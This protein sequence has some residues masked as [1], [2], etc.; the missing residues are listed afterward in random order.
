MNYCPEHDPILMASPIICGQCEAKSYPAEADWVGEVGILATFTSIHERNCP[1]R[2]DYGTVLLSPDGDVIPAV[3]R[4]RRCRAIAAGTGKPC[5]GYAQPG[6]GYC[7]TH[8]P[9]RWPS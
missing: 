1:E 4:P 7:H 5:R 8:N 2:R 6:S 9:A 3:N